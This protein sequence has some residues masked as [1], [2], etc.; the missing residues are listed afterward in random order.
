MEFSSPYLIKAPCKK[1]EVL[2]LLVRLL[3]HK[4]CSNLHESPVPETYMHNA[5][6]TYSTS[7]RKKV[8]LVL[9]KIHEN[10]LEL[11]NHRIHYSQTTTVLAH[12]IAQ[13]VRRQEHHHMIFPMTL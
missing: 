5:I 3:F 2:V 1:E 11:Q 7:H 8:V 10:T 9:E 6:Y 13:T 4:Q 12:N